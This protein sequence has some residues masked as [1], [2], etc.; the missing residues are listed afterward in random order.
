[1]LFMLIMERSKVHFDVC[2]DGWKI[3][4]KSGRKMLMTKN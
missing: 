4:Q 3:I 1:M 2:F